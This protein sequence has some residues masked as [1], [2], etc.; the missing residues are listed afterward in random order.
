MP[1]TPH[2]GDPCACICI[3]EYILAGIEQTGHFP[4][5]LYRN[6]RGE[7]IYWKDFRQDNEDT[8]R[9]IMPLIPADGE[10]QR[11]RKAPVVSTKTDYD[12]ILF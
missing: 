8:R 12:L 4:A 7:D 5:H 3:A 11:A 2:C 9:R 6:C 10:K 1:D